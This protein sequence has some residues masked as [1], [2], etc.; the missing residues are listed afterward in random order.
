MGTI[1][2]GIVAFIAGLGLATATV[3]GVVQT[4]QSAGEKPVESTN[5]SYGSNN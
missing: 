5:V 2:G 4:Q 1:T 3:V